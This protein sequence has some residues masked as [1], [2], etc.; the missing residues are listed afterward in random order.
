MAKDYT[1]YKIEGEGQS[2]SKARL[3]QKVIEIYTSKYQVNYSDLKDIWFD[4]IQGGKGVLRLFSEIDEKNERNYYMDAPIELSDGS[5]IVICN[6][7][8]KDNLSNFIFQAGIL[9]FT[10]VAE[11]EDS[12]MN[13][14]TMP[15]IENKVASNDEEPMETVFGSP[16]WELP[17]ALSFVIRHTI[18]ADNEVLEEELNW[19]QV[20]FN[21]FDEQ[22]IDVRNAWDQ[23]D[24]QAQLYE[25]MGLHD[26]LL[27]NSVNFINT[28]LS[29]S[30]K[31][32]FIQVLMQI[33]AQDDIIKHEEYITL[34]LIAK[35]FFPG[36]ESLVNETFESAG[37]KIEINN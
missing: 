21:D 35:T 6:Q 8:G 31:S 13:P 2:F 36:Q 24:E 5:K 29:E 17:Q 32:R 10:I 14:E 34:I 30:Q 20:A 1:K 27:V 18:L 37:I 19:M 33:C 3:V 23:V 26:L 7:W 12:E 15:I 11:T 22:G 16:G 4:G 9:G 28:K 25:K